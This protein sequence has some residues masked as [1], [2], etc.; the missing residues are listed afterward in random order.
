MLAH[1]QDNMRMRERWDSPIASGAAKTSIGRLAAAAEAD[2]AKTA[3][4][5]PAHPTWERAGN[6]PPLAG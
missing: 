6:G 3:A 5:W 4:A 2:F 1:K